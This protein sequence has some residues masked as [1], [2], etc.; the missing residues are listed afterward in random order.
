MAGNE[1][2]PL[3]ARAPAKVNLTLHVLGRRA[4]GYHELESLVAFAGASDHLAFT[5][6]EALSLTVEGATAGQAG[7]VEKNL[8]IKAV[9][10]LDER[11]P[12]LKLGAFRLIKNL[13]A[14]GYYT[15]RVGLLQELGYAG[16]TALAKFPACS[17]PEH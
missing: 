6:G 5:P 11:R 10:A 4:D 13:T 1:P 17:V 9:R 16:N 2:A 12:G 8:V 15:S 14:D 7:P 3:R